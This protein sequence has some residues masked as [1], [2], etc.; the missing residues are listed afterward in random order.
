MALP[1]LVASPEVTMDAVSDVDT[2]GPLP[3]R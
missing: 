2:A 1:A 3:R